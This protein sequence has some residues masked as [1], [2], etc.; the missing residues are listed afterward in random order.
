MAH[1]QSAIE[2]AGERSV[3]PMAQAALA[4]AHAARGELDE[5]L[6]LAQAAVAAFDAD[7]ALG[8][9]E[10]AA[11]L[12]LVE[13][14][15]RRGDTARASVAIAEAHERLLARAARISDATLRAAFLERIPHNAR[16]LELYRR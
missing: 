15:Q 10:T 16:T 1:G 8:E 11:R 4:R 3:P 7:R 12:V 5:A 9:D 13:I 2:A 14:L 6:D